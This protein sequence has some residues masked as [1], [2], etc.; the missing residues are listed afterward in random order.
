MAS[1]ETRDKREACHIGKKGKG[2]VPLGGVLNSPAKNIDDLSQHWGT[3]Q[4]MTGRVLWMLGSSTGDVKI[5]EGPFSPGGESDG[6]NRQEKNK[7][8]VWGRPTVKKRCVN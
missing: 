7:E 3:Q 8:C 5:R 1:P 2:R 6:R 4:K